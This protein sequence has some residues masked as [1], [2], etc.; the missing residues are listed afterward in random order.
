MVR[1]AEKFGDEAAS[2]VADQ[3]NRRHLATLPR[4]TGKKPQNRKQQQAFEADVI[5]LRRMARLQVAGLRKDHGPGQA[6]V[7]DA[8]PQFAVDEIAQPSGGQTEGYQRRDE[9]GQVQPVQ[10]RFPCPQRH[11]EQHAEKTAVE[12]HAA[13]P[14]GDDFQR[15]GQEIGRLVENH[16]A[17]AAA[18]DNPEHAVEEQV[19]ELFDGEDGRPATDA[20]AA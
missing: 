11:G 13:F 17:Q 5:E 2:A 9:I 10:A 14:D 12:A 1:L 3:E 8:S 15:M 4:S 19:V 7:G 6:G 18:D 16:L 20:Q